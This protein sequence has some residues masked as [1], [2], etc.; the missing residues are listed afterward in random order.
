MNE[1]DPSSEYRSLTLEEVA[2]LPDVPAT[3]EMPREIAEELAQPRVYI[4]GVE[5]EPTGG[6]R[7]RRSEDGGGEWELRL[8][9]GA[10]LGRPGR[11]AMVHEASEQ[12]LEKPPSTDAF[13]PA[14]I[15]LSYQASP[16]SEFKFP[17]CL[18]SVD[19]YPVQPLFVFPPDDRQVYRPDT[20]PWNCT[21]RVFVWENYIPNSGPD[22]YGSGALV[23]PRH[24]L[25]A[26][27][28]APEPNAA[29]WKMLFI[30]AFFDG[31]SVYGPG[32]QSF[33][34]NFVYL[35]GT[36]A[37][38]DVAVLRLS[39]PLG[40]QLGWMDIFDYYSFSGQW[41]PASGLFVKTAYPADVAMG[42]RPSKQENIQLVSAVPDGNSLEFRHQGDV[43]GGTSGSP[44]WNWFENPPGVRT[45]KV[46]GVNSGAFADTKTG[47]KYNVDAGGWP[48]QSIVD[49]A[50]SFWP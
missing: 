36:G 2:E 13:R 32:A 1:K 33:A 5:E 16:A 38:H 15:P 40:T 24:V 46:E 4:S 49:F 18:R 23:G 11:D 25:T 21:G 44:L 43:E 26:K 45:P 35:G 14:W 6:G 12:D 17:P 39:D 30:P 47:E 31:A 22:S 8:P 34:S 48:I 50:R 41:G 27:H 10:D 20:Y 29:N 9:P 19:G 7:L 37:A 3:A 42:A 28:V